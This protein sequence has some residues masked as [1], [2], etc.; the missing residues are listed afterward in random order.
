Q[1]R[2]RDRTAEGQLDC[3]IDAD[4][5][6]GEQRSCGLFNRENL[7][8]LS[9]L[10]QGTGEFDLVRTD[11]GT[12]QG[13]EVSANI[14]RLAQIAGQCTDVGS[15]RAGN[16]DIHVQDL[17]AVFAAHF[18]DLE[19]RNGYRPGLELHLFASAHAGVRALAINLDRR[20][21]AGDLLD[22]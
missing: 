7:E 13:G 22:V 10:L 4:R 17:A 11:R 2:G 8:F 12:A 5:A 20:D 18:M 19:S 16:G 9:Q 3:F 6:V 15:R 21:R 14:Q 1:V